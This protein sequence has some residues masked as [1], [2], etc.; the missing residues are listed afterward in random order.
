MAIAGP[1]AH[2]GVMQVDP[3]VVQRW[4][5][6]REVLIRQLDMFET[7][8]LTLKTAGVDVSQGAVTDLKRSILEFDELIS[9]DAA[10]AAQDA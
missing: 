3:L 10:D 4:R 7:G 8:R 2:L 1:R 9:A 5:D 6:L